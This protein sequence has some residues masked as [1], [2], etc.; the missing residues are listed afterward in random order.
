M[1][2]KEYKNF[3]GCCVKN[4]SLDVEEA[5]DIIEKKDWKKVQVMMDYADYY[6]DMAKE[7]Y[8]EEKEAYR[9]RCGE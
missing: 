3:L 2:E 6:W 7:Q 1:E 5:E 4:G 8:D 9:E